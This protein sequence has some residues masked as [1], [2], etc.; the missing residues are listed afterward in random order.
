MAHAVK[1]LSLPWDP[2]CLLQGSE[3]SKVS[4]VVGEGAKGVLTSWGG[5]LPRVSCTSAA[6]SCTSATLSCTSATVGW[7]RMSGRRTCG[8]SRPSLGVQVLAVFSYIS[9]GKSQF[10]KCLGTRRIVFLGFRREEPGMSQEFCRDVREPWGCSKSLCKRKF[11]RNFSFSRAFGFFHCKITW[12]TF[13]IFL[14]CFL[15][16]REESEAKGRVGSLLEIG[17][18]GGGCRRVKQAQ[19]G[20]L[21]F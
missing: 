18:H 6:L 14:N 3:T 21:A 2:E 15:G 1:T 12:R 7:S 17:G 4:K 16:D 9:Q 10:K 5:G 19:C 20:K 8:S 11:V 13:R